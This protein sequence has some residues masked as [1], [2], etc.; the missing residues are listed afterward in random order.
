MSIWPRPRVPSPKVQEVLGWIS[1][2]YGALKVPESLLL[3]IAMF[4]YCFR[5]SPKFLL[6]PCSL[7][8]FQTTQTLH[9][10]YRHLINHQSSHAIWTHVEWDLDY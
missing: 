9:R 1:Y 4:L 5:A 8:S 7:L 6:G 3:L 2:S 10:S